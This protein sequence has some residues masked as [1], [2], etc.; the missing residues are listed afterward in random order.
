MVSYRLESNEFVIEDYLKARA[1]ASFLPG[2]AGLWGIPLW[3]FYVN[4]GQA[5]A[6]FGIQ[7]KDHPIMEFQP[8]NRAYRLVAL[9]GFRTLIKRAGRKSA[10]IYEPFRAGINSPGGSVTQRMRIRLHDVG[11]EEISKQQ[12]LQTRVDYFTIPNEPYAGLARAVRITNISRSPVSFELIDGL[13]ILVPH[14]MRDFFLKN[15]SRTIEAWVAVDNLENQAPFYRLKV[16]PH[17]RPEVIPIRAGNFMVCSAHIRKKTL[18]VSPIIDPGLVFGIREDFAA[19]E[20][21]SK[22]SFTAARKQQVLDKTP[23]AMSYVKAR[24]AP[25]QTLALN[26]VFGHADMAEHVNQHLSDMRDPAF[27][28]RKA[29]EN[30]ALIA[31]LTEPIATK[32][33]YPQFDAYCRQTFLDNVLRGGSPINLGGPGGRKVFYVYSRKHGDLERD[34]NYFT[35][36]ATHF[37]Q[38]NANYRDVNQNRRNDVWFFPEV[39]AHNIHTF[40]NLLQADGFNP[41]VYKGTRYLPSQAEHFSPNVREALGKFFTPGELLRRI[42]RRHID[43]GESPETILNRVMETAH[44]V[45]DAEH[46]EGFWIDHWTYN[47][48]LLESYLAVYPEKLQPL[49]FEE[50]EFTFYDNAHTVS[51]RIQKYRLVHGA[52]RQFHAVA[53]DAEKEALIHARAENQHLMRTQGG[54]GPVYRTT[55]IVKMVCV[56]ANKAASLDPDGIGIEMEA[57]KPGWYDAL[58]G[59]PGLLGSSLCETFELKRWILFLLGAIKRMDPPHALQLPEELAE[60]IETL[61]GMWRESAAH[62]WSGSTDAKERYRARTRLGFSGVE[63][64]LPYESLKRFLEQAL[65]K[66]DRG[67]AL[68]FDK[69]SG[70]YHSYFYYEATEHVTVNQE[71]Q[72]GILPTAWTRR[73]LP[74][75]LEGMV[76][77][78]RLEADPKRAQTLHRAVE[79]SPLYDAKLSM[80]RVCASLLGATEEIGRC[81]VFNPGWLEHQSVWLHMEYKYLLEL[82]RCGLYEQFYKAFGKQLIPFQ[83]PARYGRSVLENSSFLVSSAYADSSMHGAGFVA[84]LSG[85]TAELLHMWLW[86]AIGKAPFSANERGE[87]TLRFSPVLS[88]DFFSANGKYEVTLLGHTRLIYLNPKRLPTFGRRKA[89]P[90]KITLY[91]HSGKPIVCENGLIPSPYA[92]MTRAGAMAKIEVA[93]SEK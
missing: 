3:C 33:R 41:L 54:Q 23:C 53:K 70:L 86:M 50:P 88:S 24:L 7:D 61:S 49:L 58:N 6:G 27:F 71:G 68:G 75:F 9:Q 14:G 30:Q 83:P 29:E 82:L 81:R 20:G 78:L 39:G 13:P 91:P 65:K 47:L 11:I 92:A 4:R 43:T 79:R 18:A 25:G 67:I 84:R 10:E 15:M 2:I 55:L 60:F 12:G 64:P 28:K 46:G 44:G 1:F 26:A 42:E 37:S 57:E 32:S 76:H 22:N 62:D 34:Y 36:P 16:E 45:E 40:F 21:F 51:P 35:V 38:G 52:L 48:D 19:A 85:A 73:T 90:G 80:Y 56:V 87:L 93:L 72:S 8:A 5:V 89:L 66:A 77:A 74:L 63:K 69:K 17:D 31:R 59:L